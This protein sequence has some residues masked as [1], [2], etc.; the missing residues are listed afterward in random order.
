MAERT[1]ALQEL[2]ALIPGAGRKALAHFEPLEL[3]D[4]EAKEVA[5]IAKEY[6]VTPHTI[7]VLMDRENLKFSQVTDLVLLHQEYGNFASYRQLAHA[8]KLCG[9][10]VEVLNYFLQSAEDYVLCARI[11]AKRFGYLLRIVERKY[12][13][14]FGILAQILNDSSVEQAHGLFRGKLPWPQEEE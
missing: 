11:P 8:Y 3:T 9:E 14:D 4:V 1:L 5:I 2:K 13:G 10:D 6:H 7:G 12:G